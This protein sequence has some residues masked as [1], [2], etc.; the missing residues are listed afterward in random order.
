MRSKPL[1]DKAAAKTDHPLSFDTL[2]R[3]GSRIPPTNVGAVH[4]AVR[5]ACSPYSPSAPFIFTAWKKG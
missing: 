3:S 2:M 5:P 1:V 4:R